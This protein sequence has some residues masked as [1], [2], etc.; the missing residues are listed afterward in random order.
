[1]TRPPG[2]R[3]ARAPAVA[4]LSLLLLGVA[5]PAVAAQE[6]GGLRGTVR[7]VADGAP[8]AGATLSLQGTA[9]RATSDEAG[10]FE[11]RGAPPGR[12][13]LRAIAYGFAERTVTGVEI[14]PGT[15]ERVEVRLEPTPFDVP[16]IVVTANRGATPG[17]TPASVAVLTAD[18]IRRR[19]VGSLDEALP[20]AQGVIFNADQMDIRGASGLARGV[21]SRVLMLVDGHR[22][23]SGVGGSI[24][25]AALPLLDVERVEIVK[26]PHS[27]LWGS[28][29]LGGVVNV[30]TRD[31]PRDPETVVRARYG[32]FDTPDGLGF[33]DERLTIQ[34]LD[35]QHSRR[36]GRVGATLVVGRE[37]S[38]G[39]RQNDE[40]ER[41]N[42]RAKTVFPAGAERPWVLF[43]N[44]TREDAQEFFTWRSEDRR[45][46]VS[47]EELGD[48]SR[49]EDLV[50]GLTA[51]PLVTPTAHLQVRPHLYHARVENHFH[52][53]EDF[54]R[55]T[56]YGA[57]VQLSLHPSAA[58]AA[59]VG[60]EIAVT[61]VASDFLG[62]PTVWDLALFAQDE[63][64]L[65]PR[66]TGTAGL[67]LDDHRA[68]TAERDLQLN[69]KLG[70][71]YEAS[72]RV[73]LRAS[74]SRGY[75]APSVSEQFTNTTQFGF[76]VVPNRSLTGESAWAGELGTT[77]RIGS[78]FWVDGA[79][80]WS[81]YRDL[82]EPAAVQGEFFTFQF[83]NVAEARV[84]GLDLG[85]RLDVAPGLLDLRANYVLLDAEDKRT[86]RA[87]PY[88]SDHNLTATLTALRGVGAVDVRYRSEVAEV[89]AF[90]LDPRGSITVVDLRLAYRL[91]GTDVQ[92]K[93]SNL[94]Q[95]EYVDVQE[96]NPGQSRTFLLSVTPR[97]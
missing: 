82:I 25:F 2:D 37:T 78:A 44:W 64:V 61:T 80:F 84:R 45:L 96:R 54:H 17:E 72:E 31:P 33:T 59:T 68:E 42:L 13:S 94:F 49:E 71:V 26:G 46:E 20:F 86:G 87:L 19:N 77:A 92:L 8:V 7:S 79:L 65:G 88:R 55:S 28:N 6:S 67:R 10:G 60:G 41:W 5:G 81:E 27:T 36:L 69:P 74:V 63:V 70:V 4:G 32:L 52:D 35:V 15:M 21:G 1:M 34:G 83:Q 30:V 12:Y 56:R 24:E 51:N 50:V 66:W 48:W 3:P 57:D 38:D 73:A 95:N 14:R 76:R 85:A 62:D 29:A 89:L 11:L 23:L 47:P 53:N 18:E 9:L 90:P 16:T 40:M 91:L 39:F 22:A 43:V 97:F 58:H 75:R 93:V